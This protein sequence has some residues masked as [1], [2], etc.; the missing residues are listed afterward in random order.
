M[1]LKKIFQPQFL[2]LIEKKEISK[3]TIEEITETFFK[4][5]KNLF[6]STQNIDTENFVC[7]IEGF[8]R[9]KNPCFGIKVETGAGS[10]ETFPN[11]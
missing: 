9:Y 1:I 6:E 3:E 8:L 10:F 5:L 11:F 7:T 2:H 4:S